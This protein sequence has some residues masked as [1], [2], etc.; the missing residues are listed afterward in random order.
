MQSRRSSLW[1]YCLL[2]A[3]WVAILGWQVVEHSRVEQS[4]RAE[5]RNRAKDISTTVGIV[6]RSQRRFGVISRNGSSPRSPA[7]CVRKN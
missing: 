2:V 6:L 4:A 7:W 3:A 5:L 1:V